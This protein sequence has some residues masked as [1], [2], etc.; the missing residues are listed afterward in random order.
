MHLLSVYCTDEPM[1]RDA[2]YLSVDI[3]R[4]KFYCA[5]I[6]QYPTIFH[7]KANKEGAQGRNYR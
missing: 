4:L 5:L 7:R 1:I 2:R 3:Q 6:G